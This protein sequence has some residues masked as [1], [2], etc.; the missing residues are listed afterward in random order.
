MASQVEK[1]LKLVSNQQ[2][3]TNTIDKD[4]TESNGQLEAI[5]TSVSSLLMEVQSLM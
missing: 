4:I 2:R 3:M 5:A 1:A